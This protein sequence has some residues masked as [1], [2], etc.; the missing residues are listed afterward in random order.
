MTNQ[1]RLMTVQINIMTK[2]Q[3]QPHHLTHMSLLRNQK[4]GIRANMRS[5]LVIGTSKI[6][7]ITKFYYAGIPIYY[8]YNINIEL[9]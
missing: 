3:K 8:K 7:E 1:S 4:H 6:E 5:K 9:Y 2:R